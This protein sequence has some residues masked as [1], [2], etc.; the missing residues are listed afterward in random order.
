MLYNKKIYAELGLKVPTLGRVLANS[1]KIKAAGKVTPIMQTFGDT[2]TASC[3]CSATSPTSR[4]RTRTGRTNYTANKAKYVDQPALQ[5]FLNQQQAY[6]DGYYNK[7]FA[8]ATND[9]GMKAIAT[10]TAAQ[11]PMLTG[12]ICDDRSRTTRTTST[13]SASSRCRRRTPPTPA[14]IWLPNALYIPK[15]TDGR[16]ARR[17]EE[18]RGV[19]Q[20]QRWLRRPEQG[21]LGRA[22]RT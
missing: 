3:S 2:W 15:T 8:S 1:E 21:R 20:L 7:D 5:G 16:Q 6:E 4:R 18:V 9:D 17:R 22:A 13:T 10:G 14:T 12:A 19:R 11:Y